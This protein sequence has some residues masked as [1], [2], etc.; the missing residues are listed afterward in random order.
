[1]RITIADRFKALIAKDE[2]DYWFKHFTDEEKELR[3]MDSWALA[4]VIHEETSSTG[5]S[6]KR[7]VAEHL[8]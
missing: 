4:K 8:L 3:S 5:N 7:I 6:P 1:M 2:Y